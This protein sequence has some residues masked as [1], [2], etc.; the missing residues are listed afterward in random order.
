M[1]SGSH[2]F[3]I[4]YITEAGVLAGMAVALYLLSPGR[5]PYAGKISLEMLPLYYLSFRRGAKTG[6]ITGAVVGWLILAIDPYII[7]P[8]QILL[9][10]HLPMMLVGI[11]GFFQNRIWLGV[12]IGGFCRFASHYIS[13]IIFFAAFT[14]Q[15]TNV[16]LYSLIYNASY[17]LP[18]VIISLIIMPV[19]IRRIRI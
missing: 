5:L 19:L 15:G 7:H 16:W 17:I 14:P 9:D 10:Y 4:R 3:R 1:E 2:I 13:G 12:L 6:M 8:A 18:Q 11:S